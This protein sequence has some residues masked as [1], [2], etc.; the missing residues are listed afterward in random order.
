MN[1]R[2]E[3]RRLF[4]E[5]MR[6]DLRLFIEAAFPI[7]SAG[8][9]FF[10]NWHIDAIAYALTRVLR[11][12]IKRLIITVPPRSLKSICASVAFP[13]F[14]LGQDPT[15][16]IVCVSY[17]EALARKHANDCRALMRSSIYCAAFPGARI[18][19]AKDTETEFET[20]KRGYRLAAPTEGTLTGRGGNFVIIDDLGQKPPY[21]LPGVIGPYC[22]GGSKS[23][24][25]PPS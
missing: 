19:S 22:L 14:V 1:V 24:W 6:Q 21:G 4:N 18:N 17:S 23:R 2:T 3:S 15:R 8:E 7:V 20:T 5:L 16:R 13:A 10:P 9:T 11:H 25:G 12:G